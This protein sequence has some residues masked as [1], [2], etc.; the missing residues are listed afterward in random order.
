MWALLLFTSTRCTVLT[1]NLNFHALPYSPLASE[2][3][4]TN[5]AFV[6][7]VLPGLIRES[8]LYILPC[9]LL[10]A[11]NSNYKGLECFLPDRFYSIGFIILECGF[12]DLKQECGGFGFSFSVLQEDVNWRERI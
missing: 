7:T 2:S 9:A 4:T 6:Y 10:S 8:E 3:A 1:T 12:L 5:L 11:L